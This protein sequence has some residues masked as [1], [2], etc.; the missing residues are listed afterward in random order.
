MI[1]MGSLYSDEEE[2]VLD[3]VSE[4]IQMT[5]TMEKCEAEKRNRANAPENFRE[6]ISIKPYVQY[7]WATTSN[8][9]LAFLMHLF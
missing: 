3:P 7:Q 6:L 1:R 4:K 9:R 2:D 5:W 8:S